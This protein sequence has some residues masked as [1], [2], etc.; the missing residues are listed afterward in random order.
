MAEPRRRERVGDCGRL[1][2]TLGKSELRQFEF[3]PDCGAVTYGIEVRLMLSMPQIPEIRAFAWVF[4]FQRAFS[5]NV[6]DHLH[7]NI[8]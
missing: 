8:F 5:I 6:P 7:K 1:C 2:A 4:V 3:L